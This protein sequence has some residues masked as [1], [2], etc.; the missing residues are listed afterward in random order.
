MYDDDPNVES[1]LNAV[2]VSKAELGH[3]PPEGCWTH[4]GPLVDTLTWS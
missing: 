3:N 1:Q 4:G 2:E